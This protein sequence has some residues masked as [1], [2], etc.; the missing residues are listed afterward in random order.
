M[1]ISTLAL[2]S[3]FPLMDDYIE[4]HHSSVQL[5][6][7]VGD[8]LSA[9]YP[10]WGSYLHYQL[11]SYCRLVPFMYPLEIKELYLHH[12]GSAQLYWTIGWVIHCYLVIILPST[13]WAS[14]VTS[15]KSSLQHQLFITN[16]PLAMEGYR[17]LF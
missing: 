13:R 10:I 1:L 12:H 4:C 7:W 14:R 17:S 16:Q 2:A 9:G 8:I 6:I 11:A 3:E 15:I 5:N